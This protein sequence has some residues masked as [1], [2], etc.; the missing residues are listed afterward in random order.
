VKI[1]SIKVARS[2]LISVGL[3]DILELD[4]SDLNHDISSATEPK[5]ISVD[6]VDLARLHALITTRK[7]L[8]ILELGSGF[9]SLVIAHALKMNSDYY[10][11]ILPSSLRRQDP[12]H[13]DSIDESEDWLN[14]T[15]SR[16]PMNL[17]NYVTFHCRRVSIGTFNDRPV[18]YYH[19]LPNHAYDL[20][21]VDG[22]SQYSH[23]EPDWLGFSTYD[24][25][26][27]PM[28][29]DVLRIEHFLQ[30]GTMVLFDGRSANAGFFGIN[31]QKKWRKLRSRVCDQTLFVEESEVLGKYNKE[32]LRFWGKV[33]F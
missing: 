18:T 22:P 15:K 10:H 11:G 23:G 14:I 29:A 20:I 9:S 8:N 33:K 32:F 31:V 4:K 21:Y 30:P 13:L 25:G 2:Y 1:A 24:S 27:M 26:R 5:P 19:D 12:W 7:C 3:L 16:I 28:S 6:F 17:E